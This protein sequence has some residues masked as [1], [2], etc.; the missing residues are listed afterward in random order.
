[1]ALI[2]FYTKKDDASEYN[3]E[4]INHDGTAVDWILKNIHKGQ[5]FSVYKD[6]LSKEHEISRDFEQI[7]SASEISVFLLP[8]SAI[9]V[10]YVIAAVL[11]V[12]ALTIKPAA[13][14]NL[15]R[16]Q[17]SPNNSLSDRN[18]RARPNQRIVDV[19]GKIK[20]IPDI[21]SREY[22][23]FVDDIEVRV[24]YYCVARNNL[25]IEDIKEGNTLLADVQGSSAG[26][27]GANKSPNQKI[28]GER[29][30]PDKQIGDLIKED[31]FGVTQSADAIGQVLTPNNLNT[32]VLT[33][34][35]RAFQDGHITTNS[36]DFRE[37]F[38]VG[39]IVNLVNFYVS[40]PD[41]EEGFDNIQFGQLTNTVTEVSE[42]IMRFDI[43]DDPSWGEIDPEHPLILV[44][45]FSTKIEQITDVL[46][47]PF[48]MTSF[49]VSR[50][51]VNVTALNGM[52][53]EN[54]TGWSRA[55]VE[56]AVMYQKLDDN[57]QPIGVLTTDPQTITGRNSNKK[58]STTDIDM[59]APAFVEWSVK[60]VTPL[61]FDF[62]GNVI[63]EIKLNSVFGLINTDKLEFGNVTTIQTKRTNEFLTTATKTPE[64]NCVVTELVQKYDNGAFA[65]EY[66]PN[67]Q[68]IQSLIR[69][70]LDPYIGRRSK[71]EL[72]LDLLVSL[73]DECETYFGTDNAGQFNYSFDSTSLS[74]QETFMSTAKAAFITLWREGRIL[75]G[76]FE[77]PQS[78]PAM[79]FTHRSKQ[80]NAETWNRKRNTSDSKDSIEFVYTDDTTYDKETLFFPADR[81]GVNPNRVELTG[82]KGKEQA[83]WHMMRI[84]NKQKY[85]E[86]IVDFGATAEGRFVK[87]QSLI[88][89]VK[90]SRV[91]TFDGY[92]VA[93]NGL[94]LTLSQDLVFTAGDAH[95]I[96]LKK[97]DGSTESMLVTATEFKNVVTLIE[98]PSELIYTGNDALKTEFSFGNEARLDAQLM[99]AQEIAPS[100]DQYVKIKAINYSP[101]YYQNDSDVTGSSFNLGFDLGFS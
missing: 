23:R 88:S 21:L 38:E 12:A 49:K 97:R 65:T 37:N 8:S 62:N 77:S 39:D 26:V 33:S 24:G 93:V 79:V 40:V 84:F 2:N 14:P 9:A 45:S 99:I 53:K 44:D 50:L 6:N 95:S 100:G 47:G 32:L 19:C 78:V 54:S 58:G 90:G 85:Q 31:V 63:D 76:F 25:V 96:I 16:S 18:N 29:I 10:A 80:P 72:D 4:V 48:K 28:N 66:T 15:N 71:G 82:I 27:Y 81:S 46:I 41:G 22:S 98:L 61:D 69:L 51:L 83:N 5:N 13:L 60:R 64:L 68:A 86:I 36:Q 7:K 55:T 89:V 73:Q 30:I 43:S 67:T 1:M 34:D 70:A 57:G 35:A 56:Y 94:E 101:L 87:P 3:L 11:V 74:A 75:K 52:Y 91:F 20:S 59:G 42:T 17:Q 92:V